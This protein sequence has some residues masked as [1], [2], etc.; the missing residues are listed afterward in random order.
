MDV[1]RGLLASV[2]FRPIADISEGCLTD[3]MGSVAR[4]G[5]L[6]AMVVCTACFGCTRGQAEQ[7]G[8]HRFA[9]P[10]DYRIPESDR[11]FF[12]APSD[13]DGFT[14]IL[15]PTTAL[16]QQVLVGVD[17]KANICRRAAGTEAYVNSTVCAA[18]PLQWRGRELRRSGDAVF[19]NYALVGP[20]QVVL[21]NC[22]QVSGPAKGLCMASLPF[23][24]LVLTVHIDDTEVGRLAADY[25]AA[26]AL[27]R[28]WQR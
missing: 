27:L 25:D 7:A 20:E 2:C 11:P 12:L 28:K 24:D 16:A 17:T 18:S 23:G 21:I 1:T 5:A 22:S 14:F 15:N 3:A 4:V 9:V 19:W 10:E 8:S 26:T 6:V 13:D